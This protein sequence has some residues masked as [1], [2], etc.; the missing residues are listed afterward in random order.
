M[1]AAQWG[2]GMAAATAGMEG[3]EIKVFED[4]LF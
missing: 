3:G 4:E 2:V 1:V